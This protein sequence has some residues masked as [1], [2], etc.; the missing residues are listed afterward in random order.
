MSSAGTSAGVAPERPKPA[1][2]FSCSLEIPTR[3]SKFPLSRGVRF[4]T[5]RGL[6]R[7]GFRMA[8]RFAWVF[9]AQKKPK[10][11]Y[12]RSFWGAFRS[13][14]L[15]RAPQECSSCLIYMRACA[16]AYRFPNKYPLF[17][18]MHAQGFA[19]Y[20]CA[21]VHVHIDFPKLNTRISL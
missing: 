10:F 5:F 13:F 6:P 14:G 20:P 8:R 12:K 19:W 15:P 11:H 1:R 7:L 17:V 3:A 21:R 2:D 4:S 9:A 18:F 16:R